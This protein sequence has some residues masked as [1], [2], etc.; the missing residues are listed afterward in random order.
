MDMDTWSL[1]TYPPGLAVDARPLE[2]AVSKAKILKIK[3]PVWD[4]PD[5]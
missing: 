1:G 3:S 4:C 2:K 5:R